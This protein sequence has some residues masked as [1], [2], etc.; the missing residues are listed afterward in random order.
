MT[1]LEK[2]VYV[3]QH[4]E[5]N[6]AQDATI[7]FLYMTRE[8]ANLCKST[9]EEIITVLAK[10]MTSRVAVCLLASGIE[11]EL[12]SHPGYFLS[13]TSI[14]FLV[15]AAS[16]AKVSI[17][18]VMHGDYNG[19]RLTH[20]C[21]KLLEQHGNTII[22]KHD[23]QRILRALVEEGRIHWDAKDEKGF[24]ICHLLDTTTMG[25]CHTLQCYAARVVK[26]NVPLFKNL[27]EPN[28]AAFVDN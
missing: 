28:L 25:I 8:K 1:T 14:K 12:E 6:E 4:I 19:Q 23:L 26:K 5:D 9:Q 21:G 18:V 22:R 11:Y 20:V 10:N 16:R 27:L 17:D 13:A 2:A 7:H 15:E 24:T 3:L